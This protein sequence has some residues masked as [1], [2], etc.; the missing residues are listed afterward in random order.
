MG[1]LGLQKL[2]T[3]L[4]RKQQWQQ[5]ASAWVWSSKGTPRTQVVHVATAW[6]TSRA[7]SEPS[8]FLH[9]QH[10]VP[11]VRQKESLW[12]KEGDKKQGC[13]LIRLVGWHQMKHKVLWSYKWA[14]RE[15]YKDKEKKKKQ[16]TKQLDSLIRQIIFIAYGWY[17]NISGNF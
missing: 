17:Q 10:L 3:C 11:P 6:R 7:T 1:Q 9:T 4:D 13:C 2:P 16:A 8:A 12:H 5:V 14:L 15:A